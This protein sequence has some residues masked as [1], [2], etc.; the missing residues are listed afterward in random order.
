MKD[1]KYFSKFATVFFFGLKEENQNFL[2]NACIF[3]KF[4]HNLGVR[5]AT[6]KLRLYHVN[7]QYLSEKNFTYSCQNEATYSKKIYR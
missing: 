6:D 4:H 2:N 7:A 1:F 3:E 5:N